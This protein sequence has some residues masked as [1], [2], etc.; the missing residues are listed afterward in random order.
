MALWI[1]IAVLVLAIIGLGVGTFFSGVVKGFQQL[2]NLPVINNAAEE[3]KQ[4]IHNATEN[5]KEKLVS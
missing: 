1:I 2:G 4:Y 5:V 3:V